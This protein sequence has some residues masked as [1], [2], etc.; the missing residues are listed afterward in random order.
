MA[1]FAG[2]PALSTP[3]STSFADDMALADELA[4][5]EARM[6]NVGGK[7]K[8][9]K[10]YRK[11]QRRRRDLEAALLKLHQ[12]RGQPEAETAAAAATVAAVGAAAAGA[13][14]EL[15]ATAGA[16]AE[17]AT[18]CSG[19]Y[20]PEAARGC[21]LATPGAA[22][23]ILGLEEYDPDEFGLSPSDPTGNLPD[24]SID[25]ES[26]LLTAINPSSSRRSYFVTLLP[27]CSPAFGAD[28]VALETG[29]VRDE[30]GEAVPG[31]TTL[32]LVL[33]PRSVMDVCRVSALPP[34]GA[35][36]FSDIKDLP[37]LAES[38]LDP[39]AAPSGDTGGG[40]KGDAG[41]GG[42]DAPRGA[43]AVPAPRLCGFPVGGDGAVLCSQ[44]F[45][46]AFTHFYPGTRHA[47][48]L[49]AAVGTPL[50]AVGGGVVVEARDGNLV[51]GI[52]A[53]NLFL[54]NSVTLRL[55]SGLPVSSINATHSNSS[56]K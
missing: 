55:D 34:S 15:A 20:L 12:Q 19:N 45:G 37:P 2:A 23:W 7:A 8:K 52:H 9:S 32:V 30:R 51:G 16:V 24:L 48:D 54:W 17:A 33:G 42:D 22:E 46:G 5:L 39:A 50:L 44:G 36:F 29:G 21:H 27:P 25:P 1:S 10:Q 49:D 38:L 26:L 47:L 31:C 53:K 43:A 41:G 4:A 35:E 28:G 56:K 40:A 6:A 13:S 18:R 11:L 3:S 14:P